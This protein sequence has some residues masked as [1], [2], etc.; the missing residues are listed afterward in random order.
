M[1]ELPKVRF[2]NQAEQRQFHQTLTKRVNRYFR[3]NGISKHANGQMVFKTAFMYML[4]FLPFVLMLTGVLQEWWGWT[5]GFVLMGW[6]MAGIG[7]SV[8]HDANHGSY[9]HRPWVNQLLGLSLNLVGGAS[10]TWQVQ[11]NVLHHTY[12][13]VYE[14]DED[15]SPRGLFRFSPDSK[16]RGIHRFQHLYAWFFYGLLTLS[17]VF[18]KDFKRLKRYEELGLVK[19]QKTTYWRE[20]GIILISKVFYFSYVLGLLFWL[21]DFS[22]AQVLLGFVLMHYIAGLILALIF[23]PAHVEEDTAFFQPNE[24]GLLPSAW[25]AHQLQTTS[26]FAMRS[27]LFTWYVGGLN[28]QVE[29]HL[30]PN[31]CHV[32]YRKLS[33]IVRRTAKEFNLPYNARPTFIQAL[34]YH[35]KL[36][37]QLGRKPK[38]VAA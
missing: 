8:M 13:N 5:I 31:I 21:T 3:W 12:T 22:V 30:F 4:Y 32:H 28:Y 16:F 20:F 11:H 15:I 2:S 34:W 18:V 14:M 19:K 24:E 1:Q 7:L 35:G 6:G 9:S 25:A 17:W 23:Q 27:R 38:P 10:F 26:N 33:K 37:Y 36:L 29:H